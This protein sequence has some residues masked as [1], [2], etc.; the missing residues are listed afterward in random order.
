MAGSKS[1]RGERHRHRAEHGRQQGDQVEKLFSTVHRLAHFRTPPFQGLQ[2]HTAHG[3]V[4]QLSGDPLR[5]ALHRRVIAGHGEPVTQPA[6]GL[7]QR[8]NLQ[9]GL[10]DHDPRRKAHEAASTVGLKDDDARDRLAGVA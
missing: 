2:P 5:K 4:L 3:G 8:G 9:V 1:A 10:V 7:N 6:S